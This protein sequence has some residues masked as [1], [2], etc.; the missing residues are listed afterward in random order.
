MAEAQKYRFHVALRQISPKIWQRVAQRLDASLTDLH[1][2]IQI[3]RG[4]VGRFPP[5]IPDP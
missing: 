5:S 1:Y 3:V 4:V 2:V